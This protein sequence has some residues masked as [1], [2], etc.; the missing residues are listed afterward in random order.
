M[1]ARR[2]FLNLLSFLL[3]AVYVISCMLLLIIGIRSYRSTRENGEYANDLRLSLGYVANK[4]RAEDKPGAV[5]IDE[6][7]GVETLVIAHDYDIPCE[8]RIYFYDGALFENFVVAGTDVE[9][10][11]GTRL[12]LVKSFTADV[13]GDRVTINVLDT[14][15]TARELNIKL[16]AGGEAGL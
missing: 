7:S 3:F 11:Y 5:F 14:S 9:P 10:D 15:G 4:I 2:P 16:R 6:R 8:T 13:S 1:S 12:A